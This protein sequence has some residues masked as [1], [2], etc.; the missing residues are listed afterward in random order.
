VTATV[1]PGR[2][3]H[4]PT[5]ISALHSR[6]SSLNRLLALANSSGFLVLMM[7][8]GRAFAAFGFAW[9]PLGD[10]AYSPTTYRGDMG[11]L[12]MPLVC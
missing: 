2:E 5:V 11:G 8:R 7:P 1:G 9:L 10:F 12:S 6:D 3:V 4:A